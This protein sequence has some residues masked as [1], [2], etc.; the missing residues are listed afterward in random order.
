MFRPILKKLF[1]FLSTNIFSNS[2]VGL[3]TSTS[4]IELTKSSFE[5]FENLKNGEDCTLEDLSLIDTVE[6]FER[7][8]PEY[9]PVL[10]NKR[11]GSPTHNI[12]NKVRK[13]VQYEEWEKCELKTSFN[14]YLAKK[15]GTSKVPLL[16]AV[17]KVLPK[18]CYLKKVNV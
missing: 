1:I 14:E 5:S 12:N 10:K 9:K 13:T 16:E 4:N 11:P 17:N 3:N 15:L 18:K 8:L 6:K 2:V 7:E